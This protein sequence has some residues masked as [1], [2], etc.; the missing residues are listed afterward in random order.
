MLDN[1]C[2]AQARV[3]NGNHHQMGRGDMLCRFTGH[4]SLACL[5]HLAYCFDLSML[6]TV[7][8]D[9]GRGELVLVCVCF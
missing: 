3:H 6:G 7:L 2:C 5:L 4:G 9:G 1:F 8:E